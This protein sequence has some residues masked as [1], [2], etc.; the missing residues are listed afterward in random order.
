MYHSALAFVF[1]NFKKQFQKIAF[2]HKNSHFTSKFSSPLC[3][4]P[5]FILA[6]LRPFSSSIVEIPRFVTSIALWLGYVNS[7]SVPLFCSFALNYN[8]I[9]VLSKFSFTKAAFEKCIPFA[10][11]IPQKFHMKNAL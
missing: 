7:V 9:L 2:S 5:F 3:R 1:L 10:W 8:L 4:L 6:L 11:N